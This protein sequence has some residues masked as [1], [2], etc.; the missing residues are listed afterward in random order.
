MVNQIV[1]NDD[2]TVSEQLKVREMSSN[3]RLAKSILDASFHKIC[4]L[5]K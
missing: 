2:I 3:Y 4:E 5:L 1:S